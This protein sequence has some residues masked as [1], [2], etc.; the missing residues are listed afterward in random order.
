MDTAPL[1][2]DRLIIPG[3]EARRKLGDIG[4]TKFCELMKTGELERVNIGRRSFVTVA[5][6]H[7]YV[8]RNTERKSG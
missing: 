8:A 3:P 2:D 6:L 4:W 7:A 1:T 5:S